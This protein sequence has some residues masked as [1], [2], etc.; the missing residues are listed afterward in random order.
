[1]DSTVTPT[2]PKLP[3]DF[4]VAHFLDRIGQNPAE[5][6]GDDAKVGGLLRET[7]LQPDLAR[8]GLE[9]MAGSAF[10]AIRPSLGKRASRGLVR[11]LIVFSGGVSKTLAWQSDCDAARGMIATS[12]PQ[13]A[14]LA[15]ETASV[16]QVAPEQTAAAPQATASPEL[17]QLKE[18]LAQLKQELQQL[19]EIPAALA[20]L[21]QSV[22][23]LAGS[24]QQ[25][26][27]TI[28]K[29][30]TQKPASPPRPAP[31]PAP[32][33][34]TPPQS[35][36]RCRSRNRLLPIEREVTREVACRLR[37]FAL[38]SA[39]VTISAPFGANFSKSVCTIDFGAGGKIARQFVLDR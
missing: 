11:F 13:L 37:F 9:A 31:A 8:P 1:M 17:Q 38:A 12:W 36:V 5:V 34:L 3:K 6:D 24:Q 10:G 21:R 32:K 16:P 23:R 20:S 18:D 30:G 25:I 29:L 39:S 35:E 22:D 27:G 14:S 33:P 7:A 26:V 2:P 28:A 4:T 15:P 19:K